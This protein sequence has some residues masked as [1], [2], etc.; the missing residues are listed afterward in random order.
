MEKPGGE[1]MA[2]DFCR[3]FACGGGWLVFLARREKT[4]PD[5]V[6][7]QERKPTDGANPDQ[8]KLDVNGDG[9]APRTGGGFDYAHFASSTPLM[10]RFTRLRMSGIL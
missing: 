2:S 1:G 7:D 5:R 9:L 3:N 4:K 8:D 6:A 10:A